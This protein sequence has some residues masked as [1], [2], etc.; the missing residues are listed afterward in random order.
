[1]LRSS[2]VDEDFKNAMIGEKITMTHEEKQR[3]IELNDKKAIKK[4]EENN[5][6]L[7]YL[8]LELIHKKGGVKK[9]CQLMSRTLDD[10]FLG[11]S[12]IT[13]LVNVIWS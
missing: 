5:I 10:K 7:K 1:M 4:M 12:V 6:F 3:T 8:S 2:L 9:F 13:I 11:L